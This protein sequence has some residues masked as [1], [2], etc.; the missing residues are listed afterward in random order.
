MERVRQAVEV[1]GTVQKRAEFDGV[2]FNWRGVGMCLA[3]GLRATEMEALRKA[4]LKAN[5]GTEARVQL[6][7][8]TANGHEKDG[9]LADAMRVVEHA[10]NIDPLNLELHHRRASLMKRM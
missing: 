7:M 8:L 2:R 5:P 6:H 4:F 1:L 10:L 3:A 9:A